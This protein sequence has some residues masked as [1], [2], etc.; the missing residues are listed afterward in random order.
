MEDFYKQIKENLDHR[1][2]PA[3]EKGDWED[4]EN[5]LDRRPKRTTG[6]FS[7][8][9]VIIPLAALLLLSNACLL[10]ELKE[11]N[12]QLADYLLQKDTVY[13]TKIIYLTDTIY[14]TRTNQEGA[15]QSK[16]V[17]ASSLFHQ[18]NPVLSQLHTF[19]LT[20]QGGGLLPASDL[21]GPLLAKK[22]LEE[23]YQP[24]PKD[25]LKPLLA[26]PEKIKL[27]KLDQLNSVPDNSLAVSSDY[28][29]PVYKKNPK[30]LLYQM[31]PKG[32]GLGINGGLTYPFNEDLSNSA[33]YT[34]G[35][36]A[37]VNF[38]PRLSMWISGS[39]Q[40]VHFD[41]DQMGESIGVPV[42]SP[43]NDDF[44][45]LTAE[46]P[47]PSLQY[48]AGMRYI[49]TGQFKLRP[50]IGIGYASVSLLPYE[51]NYDFLDKNTGIEWVFEESVNLSKSF[52]GFL[53]LRTGMEREF[54]EHWLWKLELS[55]RNGFEDKEFVAPN[56]LG[57]ETGIYYKF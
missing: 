22:W 55:Y 54:T 11:S 15:I 5:K 20:G 23:K 46:V 35:A 37:M 7:F 25:N 29:L 4:L 26:S 41:S 39:Y 42:V 51:V 44:E 28:K 2:E 33:G 43:P 36:E 17:H 24:A 38:S 13:Q 57:I 12:Q 47:Q 16:P 19:N 53:L 45:F 40:N 9:W 1:P 34:I 27:A 18:S 31:R 52:S 32:L 14:Q 8:W 6:G 21:A 50:F 30:R 10:I 49:L 56:L 3:F 48:S